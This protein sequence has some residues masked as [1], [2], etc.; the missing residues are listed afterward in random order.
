MALERLHD[1]VWQQLAIRRR[2]VRIDM[3]QLPHSRDDRRHRRVAQHVLEGQ[4][5]EG[6]VVLVRHAV[7]DAL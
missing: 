1:R 3:R 4:S 2:A 6:G 5:R 7:A